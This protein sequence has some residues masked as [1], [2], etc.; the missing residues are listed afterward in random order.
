MLEAT[1]IL[2]AEGGRA[3]PG[4]GLTSNSLSSDLDNENKSLRLIG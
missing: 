4:S 2:N 3:S 1:L